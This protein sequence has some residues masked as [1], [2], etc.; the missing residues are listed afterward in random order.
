MPL[1]RGTN[2][3]RP[4]RTCT[5]ENGL[6]SCRGKSAGV[7]KRPRELNVTIRDFSHHCEPGVVSLGS[8]LPVNKLAGVSAWRLED[9]ERRGRVCHTC[10]AFR[11]LRCAFL[12]LPPA[13]PWKLRER[14]RL[15]TLSHRMEDMSSDGCCGASPRR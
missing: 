8:A 3:K 10:K 12:L 4:R 11:P 14:A 5:C 6:Q 9:A 1:E 13:A 2:P 7:A 15:R